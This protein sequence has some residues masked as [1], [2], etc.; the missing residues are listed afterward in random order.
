MHYCPKCSAEIPSHARFCANC[1][2]KTTLPQTPQEQLHTPPV[3]PFIAS[4]PTRSVQPTV[5]HV[6]HRLNATNG[7]PTDSKPASEVSQATPPADLEEPS[8]QQLSTPAAIVRPVEIISSKQTASS[9]DPSPSEP[10]NRDDSLPE[11]STSTHLLAIG[12]V[13]SPGISI[14]PAPEQTPVPQEPQAQKIQPDIMPMRE[15]EQ[16]M[17]P[18][19]VGEQLAQ[20]F[21]FSYRPSWPGQPPHI[22]PTQHPVAAGSPGQPPRFPQLPPQQQPQGGPPQRQPQ[23]PFQREPQPM[24]PAEIVKGRSPSIAS[25]EIVDDIDE[26]FIVT[27]QAA[28]HWH[29]SWYARQR[30]EAGPAINVSRGQ[31]RVPEPLMVMQ[32]SL[33]RIRAIVLP[34]RMRQKQ[35][36]AA[37]TFWITLFLII[38]LALG[39]AGFIAYSYLPS[40]DT[41]S[42]SDTAITS[43]QPSLSLQGTSFTSILQG[44]ALHVHGDNFNAGAPIIFLLDGNIT[45][46]DAS[47]RQLAISA[48]DQGSFNVTIPTS[49]L[50]AGP[51]II[52]AQDNKSGQNAYLNIQVNLKASSNTASADVALSQSSKLSFYA[53]FGQGDP[54]KQVITLTNRN[55][56]KPL[57]WT[58]TAIV[59]HNLSWLAIDPSTSSGNISVR[60]KATVNVS[61]DIAGLQ[62]SSTPYTGSIVFT[63]NQTEQLTLPVELEVVNAP[64]EIF[65][66]PNPLVGVLDASGKACQTDSQLLL[67]NISNTPINW[68]ITSSSHIEFLHN[69]KPAMQGQLGASGQENDTQ[70]LTLQCIEVNNG[71]VYSFSVVAN[72]VAWPETVVIQ[73][74]P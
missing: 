53:F 11:L 62:S 24:P 18:I 65:I 35:Q 47:G 66:S 19:E 20:P 12:P 31:S 55:A 36:S 49:T 44:Q 40:T 67:V 21:Q 34:Q 10:T 16:Q 52:S 23:P 70:V 37:L 54:A 5:K 4:T 17:Q 2:H 25:N 45:I 33:G 50:S 57:A 30:V 43:S 56:T 38:G 61:V 9:A 15:R 41:A 68:S 73:T 6:P 13:T 22:P 29:A 28:E 63:I 7:V 27:S 8:K 26:G 14:L 1:G 3:V 71:Q 46:N 60:G 58:A 51:H 59:D 72:N 69:G 48:S 74:H 42:S 64:D 32:H 39:L